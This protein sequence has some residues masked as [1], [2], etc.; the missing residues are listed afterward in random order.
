[1]ENLKQGDKIEFIGDDLAKTVITKEVL[2][3][4]GRIVFTHEITSKGATPPDFDDVEDLITWGWKLV[5]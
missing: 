1:M 3:V 4:C 2:G 5:K